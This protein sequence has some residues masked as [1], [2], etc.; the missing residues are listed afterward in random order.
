MSRSGKHDPDVSI[1]GSLRATEGNAEAF[2]LKGCRIPEGWVAS[3]VSSEIH[4]VKYE[5]CSKSMIQSVW[6][7]LVPKLP[8]PLVANSCRKRWVG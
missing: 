1:H 7:A 4:S 8:Q 3:V 2:V 5:G 6:V